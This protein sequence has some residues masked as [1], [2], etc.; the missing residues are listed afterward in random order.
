MKTVNF[1]LETLRRLALSVPVAFL[2]TISLSQLGSAFARDVSRA[3]KRACASDYF[4]HC[5]MFA[6]G[7]PE[8]RKC[9]R[10][11]GPNLSRGCITALKAAGEVTPADR[12]RYSKYKTARN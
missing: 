5:S 2:I 11:V 6:V 7:T 9:M 12:R 10:A 8:V 4:A 1:N 3:V